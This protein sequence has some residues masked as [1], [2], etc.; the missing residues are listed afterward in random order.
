MPVV[1]KKYLLVL[2]FLIIQGLTG[3][4]GGLIS[5]TTPGGNSISP[6]VFIHGVE[7]GGLS[8]EQAVKLLEQYVTKLKDENIVLQYGD[9]QWLLSYNYLGVKFDVPATVEKA[10]QLGRR[11]K[12]LMNSLEVIEARYRKPVL[13]V[14]CII[15]E[16]QLKRAVNKLAS[17]IDAPAKNASITI[18]GGK[19]KIL[20]HIH[21]KSLRLAGNL[22]NIKEALRKIKAA[23]V[24]LEVSEINP[25]I[26]ASDLKGIKE[27][28]G[29]GVT[30][31]SGLDKERSENIL[32]AVQT[33]NGIVVNPGEIFSFNQVVGPRVIEKGYHEAPLIIEGRLSRGFGGGVCQVATTLYQ[34]VIY[35]GLQVKERYA[36]SVP[37]E[38]IALGQ[39]AA[40]AYGKL[41]LK[42]ENTTEYPVYMNASVK[43]NCI[44][45]NLLGV[46]EK[47]QTIQ[48]ITRETKLKQQTGSTALHACVYRLF[49]N[50]GKMVKQELVSE[51]DYMEKNIHK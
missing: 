4:M 27:S 48:V 26:L 22:A 49:Y 51:D 25:R 15:N 36:H 34:A 46:K 7:V 2:V 39:D 14:E 13:P 47:A 28:L 11:H 1:P 33:L 6:G 20:P 35:S 41:D 17:E 18:E 29:F 37:P 42:F 9:R 38:Y 44:S 21:G 31:F 3:I 24:M 19:L 23:P 12:S 8:K 45:I 32:L 30:T 43:N 16:L 5:V 10:M 50:N 40:V